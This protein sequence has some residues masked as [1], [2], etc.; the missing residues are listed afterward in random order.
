[1]VFD[2]N[3]LAA[4]E[5]KVG[6]VV[7][8]FIS[9][10]DDTFRKSTI[11][12]IQTFFQKYGDIKKW[13]IFSDYALY[14]NKKS[15]DVIVFSFVPY[16]LK[17]K[18]YIEILKNIAPKDIKK[19]KVISDQFIDFLNNIPIINFAFIL[20]KKRKLA[21]DEVNAFLSWIQ[22]AIKMLECWE[23]TT[24][25]GK[26][27]YEES[28]KKFNVIQK[29][30]QRRGSDLTTI[31]D[32]NILAALTSYLTNQIALIGNIENFCWLSDRD[33]LLSF[34][35]K[36][37]SSPIVFDLISYYYHIFCE[38][39]NL[40]NRPELA[41]GIPEPEGSVWYDSFNRIP[42][43]IAGALADYNLKTNQNSHSKFIKIFENFFTNSEKVKIF[44]LDICR[45]QI[46]TSKVTIQK[47]IF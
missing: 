15:N 41:F 19:T 47:L 28:I 1:M 24:P 39:D 31:R 20:N 32:I 33:I 11:S 22:N 3:S 14:D 45:D 2:R 29:E 21:I 44:K 4:V 36:D 30:L 7:P 43:L 10:L 18:E 38:N 23:I 12:E 6:F 42:D 8:D 5:N 25:R 34:K 16:I 17:F 9:Y 13:M 46:S 26:S 37:I 40:E 27:R 35:N